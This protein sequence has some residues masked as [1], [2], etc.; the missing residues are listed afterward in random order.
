MQIFELTQPRKR[1]LKELAP[2]DQPPKKNYGTGVGPGVQ[3][4]YTATPRMKST[5][6]PGKAPQLPAP[7]TATGAVTT[8]ASAP[9]LQTI[10]AP[11][12][13]TGPS[14]AKQIGTN[15]DPNVTDV[16]ARPKTTKK[17][18]A[19]LPEP[20]VAPIKTP[21]AQQSDPAMAAAPP[22]FAAY[23]QPKYNVPMATAPDTKIAMS[24]N[25]STTG[26]PVAAPVAA[27]PSTPGVRG[28]RTGAIVGALGSRLRDKLAADAG[29]SG[30]PDTGNNNA[31]GDQR[32]AAAK[33]AGPLISQQ[34][35]QELAKWN[36][37]VANT[38]K[39]AGVSSPAQLPQ[40]SRN[41][42]KLSLMNQ[43]NSN[44]LQK[45]LGNNYKEL[46]EYVDDTAQQ[47][48]AAQIAKLDNAINAI[49]NFNAPK[50]DSAAELQRWQDLSQA[51]Y[52]M[53]SLMKFHPKTVTR[54]VPDEP[55]V[56][57]TAPGAAPANPDVEQVL[58]RMG[59]SDSQARVLAKKVPPGTS[60]QEAVKQI[61]QGR[62]AESLTWSRSFDPSRT[63]LKK[64]KQP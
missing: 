16:V 15:Y 4:Q 53:R 52:D 12:Q 30:V 26:T 23:D 48:A 8:T 24:T 46:P 58:I 39:Q 38:V 51:T 42:L 60:T 19:A 50:S 34:A 56:K 20:V 62:I 45:Q 17:T 14:A 11:P 28:S 2:N 61:L 10:D 9:E 29:L 36:Q 27:A 6:P 33:A 25:M 3:P 41:A 57:S 1:T 31:Y 22:T 55:R 18:P 21:P 37:A 49:L 5:P 43:V 35:R 40:A 54:P 7:A 47:E 44:F 13:L 32:A 59:Y 64:I 63:L